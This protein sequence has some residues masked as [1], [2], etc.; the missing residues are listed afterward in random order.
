VVAENRV[1]ENFTQYPDIWFTPAEIREAGGRTLHMITW[2]FGQAP[3]D[4]GYDPDFNNHQWQFDR[5][6]ELLL[7]GNTVVCP[8]YGLHIRGYPLHELVEAS[9]QKA[10]IVVE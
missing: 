7:A 8:M 1:W 4:S 2:P 6:K 5:T 10:H 9:Q 3:G